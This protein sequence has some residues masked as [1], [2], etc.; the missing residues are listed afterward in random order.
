MNSVHQDM[1]TLLNLLYDNHLMLHGGMHLSSPYSN[2]GDLCLGVWQDEC[3]KE[4]I[5]SLKRTFGPFKVSDSNTANDSPPIHAYHQLTGGR[6]VHVTIYG[7]YVCE[8]TTTDRRTL[9]QE[10]LG[11]NEEQAD[12]LAAQ[13][14]ALRSKTHKVTNTYDCSA[15][16]APEPKD[17]MGSEGDPS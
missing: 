10:E 6:T 8:I 4:E 2:N 3:T 7:A 1:M 17:D 13:A 14:L 16:P 5:T 12:R 15:R 9:T 11:H